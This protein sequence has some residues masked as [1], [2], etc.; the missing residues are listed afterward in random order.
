MG[1]S[2]K[3]EMVSGKFELSEEVTTTQLVDGKYSLAP[4]YKVHKSPSHR[5]Y[6]NQL[7][8]QIDLNLELVCHVGVVAGEKVPIITDRNPHLEN[9]LDSKRCVYLPHSEEANIVVDLPNNSGMFFT[10]QRLTGAD[11]YVCYDRS[12]HKYWVIVINN[13]Y[14]KHNNLSPDYGSGQEKLWKKLV[15]HQ[16]Y[17]DRVMELLTRLGN[18]VK[19]IFR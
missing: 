3:Y 2:T 15:E 17:S 7:S 4:L 14:S 11:C 19:I 13:V 16:A 10:T 12:L 9:L 1:A 5:Q 18:H 6:N 8:L